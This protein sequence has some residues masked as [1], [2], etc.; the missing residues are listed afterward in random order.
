MINK[1]IL[2]FVTLILGVALLSQIAVVAGGDITNKVTKVNDSINVQPAKAD[3][4]GEFNASVALPLSNLPTGWKSEDCPITGASV[5]NTSGE[6]LTITTDYLLTLSTGMLY[7]Q[8]SS[9]Y[10]ETVDN[11]TYVTYTYCADEYINLGW[12]RTMLTLVV[13]FFAIALLL[14]SI[15][16]FYGIAKDTGMLGM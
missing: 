4:A 3:V 9:A 16:I 1:L 13:G 6:T 5:Q 15:G 8:N 11:I 2:G 10:N 14:A 7:M 12:G